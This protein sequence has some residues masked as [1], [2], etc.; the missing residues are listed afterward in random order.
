VSFFNELT[1][2]LAEEEAVL[3]QLFFMELKGEVVGEGTI[4]NNLEIKT[5]KKRE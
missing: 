2:A 5:L 3:R 1:G 4:S